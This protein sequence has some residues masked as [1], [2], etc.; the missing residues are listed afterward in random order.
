MFRAMVRITRDAAA[1]IYT[2]HEC[3]YQLPDRKWGR[4]TP[5]KRIGF[6]HG[7]AM[8]WSASTTGFVFPRSAPAIGFPVRAPKDVTAYAIPKRALDCVKRGGLPEMSIRD[9]RRG[10]KGGKTYPISLGSR[11]RLA[12]HG[13][14]SEKS[15]RNVRHTTNRV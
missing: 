10:T 5:E 12:R 6:H 11:A 2:V 4:R 14:H 13:A 15:A 1:E 3:Q 9:H 8:P 7:K